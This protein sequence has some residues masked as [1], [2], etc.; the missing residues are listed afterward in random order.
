MQRVVENLFMYKGY[1]CVVTFDPLGYRCG[2]VGLP[3][4]HNDYGK[5]YYK[6]YDIDCHGGLTF[7]NDNLPEL[8][9]SKTWW[10]GFDCS[11][12][13]DGWDFTT[14]NKYYGEDPEFKTLINSLSNAKMGFYVGL[15][16]RSQEYVENECRKIVAQIAGNVPWYI[17]VKLF[18]SEMIKKI[19][20]S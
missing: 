2:Y 12:A 18:F 15:P 20:K 6:L 16:A 8:P 10:I 17:K 19:L 11:H 5:P 14:A 4:Y 13:D 1:P 7:A 9:Y 3:K